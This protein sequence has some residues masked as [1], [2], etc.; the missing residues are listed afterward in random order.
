MLDE[1][2]LD[3]LPLERVSRALVATEEAHYNSIVS[4]ALGRSLG[5]DNVFQTPEEEGEGTERSASLQGL[6]VWGPAASFRRLTARAWQPGETFRTTEL[7]EGENDWKSF[8]ARWPEATVMLAAVKNRI[9]F[10]APDEEP[11]AGAKL[12]FLPRAGQVEPLEL[13][14]VPEAETPTAEAPAD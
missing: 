13:P 2:E 3:E 10:P 6:P 7:R 4:L 12:V 11:P 8:Q 9:L 1:D 5:R 14:E